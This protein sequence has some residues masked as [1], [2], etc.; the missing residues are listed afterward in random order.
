[1]PI[2]TDRFSLRLPESQDDRALFAI[3]SDPVVMKYW[4]TPPWQG[5][6]DA[7]A[8]IES[9]RQALESNETLT[10]V[11]LERKTKQLIGKCMLF[12]YDGESKRAEIGFGVAKPYWGKGV[13]QEVGEALIQFG[14]NTLGLRRIEAEIDPDNVGSANALSRLGFTQEGLL[15]ARWEVNGVVSDSALYGRLVTDSH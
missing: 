9:C 15:R 13:I 8:F 6:H 10:Y 2:E 7:T 1:M 4:N 11:I 3:F 14:F 12:A 5:L